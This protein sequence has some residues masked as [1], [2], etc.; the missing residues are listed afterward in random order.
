M[1]NRISRDAAAAHLPLAHTTRA[2]MWVGGRYEFDDIWH[3][4]FCNCFDQDAGRAGRWSSIAWTNSARAKSPGGMRLRTRT[5]EGRERGL[6]LADM[7]FLL[8]TCSRDRLSPRGTVLGSRTARRRSTGTWRVPFRR[9]GWPDHVKR[10]GRRRPDPRRA[11][12][13]HREGQPPPQGEPRKPWQPLPQ[14]FRLS[15]GARPAATATGAR[16]VWACC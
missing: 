13:Q 8:R 14:R 6:T 10:S 1:A 9:V 7:R 3:D 2:G 16:P 15:A 5:E 12:S 4:H 11:A